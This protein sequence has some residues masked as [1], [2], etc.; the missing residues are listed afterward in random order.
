MH[1]RRITPDEILRRLEEVTVEDIRRV[2]R[3]YFTSEAMSLAALGNLNGF[4]VDRA[5]LEI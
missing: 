1:G 4:K 2:A 5:R 3:E